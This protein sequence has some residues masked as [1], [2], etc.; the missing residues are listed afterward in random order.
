MKLRGKIPYHQ[1]CAGFSGNLVELFTSLKLTIYLRALLYWAI[2]VWYL[3][4]ENC[5]SQHNYLR[6]I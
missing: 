6:F 2:N 4:D 3:E 5:S 1:T